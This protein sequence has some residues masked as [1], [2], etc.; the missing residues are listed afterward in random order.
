M[1]RAASAP[2]RFLDRGFARFVSRSAATDRARAVKQRRAAHDLGVV[3]PPDLDRFM[4]ALDG[5]SSIADFLPRPVLPKLAPLLAA[6]RR[7]GPA[8]ARLTALLAEAVPF[9]ETND[10][11]VVVYFLADQARSII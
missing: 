3:L 8:L 4:A 5:T 1:L 7:G 10:G 2:E 9:G 6:A 11:E